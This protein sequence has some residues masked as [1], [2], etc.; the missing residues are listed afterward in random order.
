MKELEEGLMTAV[1]HTPSGPWESSI[2]KDI[3]GGDPALMTDEEFE[4]VYGHPR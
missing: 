1:T 3:F 2:E 4:M